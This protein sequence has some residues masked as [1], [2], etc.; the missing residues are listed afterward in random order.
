MT[1]FRSTI[2]AVV[3]VVSLSIHAARGDNFTIAAPT[4]SELPKIVI[5]VGQYHLHVSQSNGTIPLLNPQGTKL[6]PLLTENEFC[7]AAVEGAVEVDGVVYN[8]AGHGKTR[9]VDCAPLIGALAKKYDFGS[10][11]FSRAIGPY[12]DGVKGNILVPFRTMT[13][14]GKFLAPG[15][16]VFIPKAVGVILP[17]DRV[18]DGY[19]FVGDIGDLQDSRVDIFEGPD[20]GPSPFRTA[21]IKGRVDAYKIADEAIVRRLRQEHASSGLLAEVA[22][23]ELAAAASKILQSLSTADR[24]SLSQ[25]ASFAAKTL[26]TTIK[27][28]PEKQ[29]E[30]LAV[31]I[32]NAN[33]TAD[34][35]SNGFRGPV[36]KRGAE[37][38]ISTVRLAYIF[39]GNDLVDKY[40]ILYW[41]T[42]LDAY[43]AS[44]SAIDRDVGRLEFR[45]LIK[46][47]DGVPQPVKMV[48]PF[49]TAFAIAPDLMVTNAHVI[50]D[51]IGTWNGST[52]KYDMKTDRLVQV[53]LGVEYNYHCTP[54]PRTMLIKRIVD[55]DPDLDVAVL[56][57]DGSIPLLP[58]PLSQTPAAYD[59]V[60]A[61]IGYPGVDPAIKKED[62]DIVFVAPDGTVPYNI[63]RFQPG[64]VQAITDQDFVV[65]FD[66]DA[67]TLVGNSGSPVIRVSDGTVIGLHHHGIPYDHNIATH[68]SAMRDF[69]NKAIDEARQM[70]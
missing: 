65:W 26:Q 64:R 43:I 62:Q 10:R 6:G 1:F 49:A 48:V 8:V 42:T 27:T 15:T 68:I 67:S 39:C 53:E 37:A 28:A 50:P 21:G 54:Q 46:N 35:F 44:Y 59:E 31:Q 36:S 47:P 23:A 2:I 55:F 40:R 14:D 13:S 52:R 58:L 12:G 17:G 70:Q 22:S 11:R 29:K 19:F 41:Q 30:A 25:R 16:V 56:K 20:Q 60:V 18:H 57:T 45:S 61:I 32:I 66:H 51:L 33:Y 7:K 24:A 5:S 9:Q 38:I 4:I 69:L 63:K 3:A 34:T